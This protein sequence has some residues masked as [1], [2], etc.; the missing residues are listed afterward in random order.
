MQYKQYTDEAGRLNNFAREPKMYAA[1][2][3]TSKQKVNYVFMGI[4]SIALIAG[5]TAIAF[6]IQ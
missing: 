6:N 3:P 1:E 5:L 4:A 2:P